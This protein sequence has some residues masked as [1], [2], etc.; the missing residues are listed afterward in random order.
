MTSFL[1]HRKS[2][3]WRPLAGL[4]ALA[5]TASGAGDPLL[6]HTGQKLAFLG[7]S[8]T[9]FGW[10]FPG[11]YVKLVLDGLATEGVTVT[12]I[13]AGVSGNTSKDM[14][15]RLDR[16]V[17]SKHPDWMTLSCGVN[18]VWHG[19]N[20]GVNLETYE[21]NITAIIDQATAQGVKVV[22][23]TS[24]PI[25][26]NDNPMNQK[27]AAYNDFLRQLA[28][29]RKLPLADTSAAFHGVLQK[30]P[31]SPASRFL[32]VDGVHMNPEGNV[33]MAKAVLGSFGVPPAGLDAAEQAWL[34][35]PDTAL[36]NG[37]PDV[38]SNL[39]I[40]LAQYR[41]LEKIAKDSATDVP[42]VEATVWLRLVS[43]AV[44]K[45][46]G[47]SV[48]DPG[49]IQAEANAALPSKLDDLLKK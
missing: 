26:E 29:E 43:E 2:P 28:S 21:K 35:R 46:A 33:L 18:D 45:H 31:T 19:D 41:G 48:L 14:L 37:G 6:I 12:P 7:D 49:K 39:K 11:G 16:D 25:V 10:G 20:G 8:I 24:T 36:F 44:Q 3:L 30:L 5:A 13:P 27:L 15:A 4:F 47:D 42:A 38:R 34:A 1:L 40:G 22:I 23:M 9:A 17:L 32:T